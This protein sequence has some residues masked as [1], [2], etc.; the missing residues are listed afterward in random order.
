LVSSSRE[1]TTRRFAIIECGSDKHDGALP[2][3]EKYSSGYFQLKRD[4]SE[5]FC[6]QFWILSAEFGLIPSDRVI[7]DYDTRMKDVDTAEWLSMVREQFQDV[8]VFQDEA[9][10]IW[11]MVSQGKLTDPAQGLRDSTLRAF[12]ER[13]DVDIVWPFDETAGIGYQQGWLSDSIEAGRVGMPS[14]FG[15]GTSTDGATEQAAI[16]AF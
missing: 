8:D 10:E 14:D 11:V 1:E 12:L 9:A 3:K 13:V 7:P 5:A 2:A 15:H 6:D 4:W 16:D